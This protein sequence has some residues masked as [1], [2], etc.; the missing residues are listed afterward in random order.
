[1]TARRFAL[2]ASDRYLGVFKAFIDCG[3]EPVKLFS[4]PI[5]SP[6]A[7]NTQV[8]ELAQQ[9]KIPIQLSRMDDRNLAELADLGCE[10]LVLAS[11]Q[12]RV[13]DWSRHLPRAINFHPA[14]LP[15]YRGPYPLVQGLL[16]RAPFWG[17]TCHKVAGD[18]DSGDILA[19]RR[20]AVDAYE[21]HESLDLKTQL[22]G[23]VLALDVAKNLDAL[24]DAA[25]PQGPGRYVQNWTDA[26]REI[27][28]SRSVEDIA[29]Q[30]R[31]F[32]DFECLATVNGVRFFVR[33]ALCWPVAHTLA[34]GTL[35]YIDGTRYVV[36]CRDGFMALL[37][38][39]MLPAGVRVD[40]SLR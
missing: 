34:P 22:V 38:W 24:W 32:G 7:A 9:H 3:W 8:I 20:F 33:R 25:Q 37:Q 23:R 27:D 13:G 1:M 16:D 19:E 2:T 4:A 29:L 17:M 14:P 35:V 28:F 40:S 36:A 6:M 30:L 5:S 10:L 15:G 21:C 26:D 18:F 12:W 31:A 39:S 11:Y